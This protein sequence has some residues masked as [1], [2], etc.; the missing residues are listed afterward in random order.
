MGA[1]LLVCRLTLASVFAI[2][3]VAKLADLTGSRRAAADFGVPERLAPATGVLLPSAEIAVAVALIPAPAAPF[4]A[5]G[6]AVLLACFSAA[7]AG[8]NRHGRTPDCHCFGQL[9]S[10]PAGRAALIRNAALLAPAGFVAVSGWP[11][12]AVGG[13]AGATIAL[14]AV[15]IR[16]PEA[17]PA[18]VPSNALGLPAGTLAPEFELDAGDGARHSLRSLLAGATRLML[19]FTDSGCATCPVLLP[20]VARVQRRTRDL[21]LAVALVASGDRERNRAKAREHDIELMLLQKDREV[22]AAYRVPGTPMAVL[23]D[24]HGLIAAETLAGPDAILEALAALAPGV[25]D[26]PPSELG[27]PIP[28]LVLPGLDGRLLSLRELYTDPT[29]VVFWDPSCEFSRQMLPGL[30]AFEREA[31]PGAPR[32]VADQRRRARGGPGAGSHL[33]RAPGSRRA[34]GGRLRRHRHPD[35]GAAL[36]GSDRLTT[37]SR[38]AHRVQPDRRRHARPSLGAASAGRPSLG[39]ASAGRA[40]DTPRNAYGRSRLRA[41]RRSIGYAGARSAGTGIGGRARPPLRLAPQTRALGRGGTGHALEDL[42]AC[43]S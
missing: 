3:G 14:I 24:A 41:T 10:A 38:G 43:D 7:I 18:R 5:L 37:G 40:A 6:A 1:A 12:A 34:G 36:R 42:R 25:L 21:D 22:A 11:G 23:V 39:A 32:L 31:P 16:P 27:A 29:I 13:A 9:H 15:W 2:A 30:L 19:V 8:A 28:D 35:G 33:A 20:E 4:A 17:P 26:E